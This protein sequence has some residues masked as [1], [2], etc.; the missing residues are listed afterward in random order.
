MSA[1][2]EN[3]A[4]LASA[5]VIDGSPIA[6][7]LAGPRG[8]GDGILVRSRSAGLDL[9][10]SCSNEQKDWTEPP[11]LYSPLSV[12]GA[13][14]LPEISVIRSHPVPIDQITD[15][16]RSGTFTFSWMGMSSRTDQKILLSEFN[17]HVAD[18][19][20]AIAKG[21]REQVEWSLGPFVARCANIDRKH[22]FYR[23]S[24][25]LFTIIIIAGY[26]ISRIFFWGVLRR[27]E[28]CSRNL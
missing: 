27:H 20:H 11:S 2:S 6:F 18:L 7:V 21:D 25:R 16:Q 23:N 24:I 17:R 28:R 4:S 13:N 14:Y 5:I 8:R 12:L 3:K 26:L 15:D 1:D 22:R 19:Q 9:I 10:G